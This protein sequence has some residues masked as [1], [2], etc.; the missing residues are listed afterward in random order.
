MQFLQTLLNY[1]LWDVQ[2]QY[3]YPP[4]RLQPPASLNDNSTCAT[5]PSLIGTYLY[6]DKCF[7][8]N[9]TDGLP[10][11]LTVCRSVDILSRSAKSSR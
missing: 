10:A 6:E 2:S 11:N 8:E 9:A 1:L 5:C 3:N 4:S 7:R